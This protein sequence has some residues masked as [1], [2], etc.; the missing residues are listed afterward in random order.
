MK[1]PAFYYIKSANVQAVEKF[2]LFYER[3]HFFIASRLRQ[4]L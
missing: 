1:F 2:R 3:A 4:L